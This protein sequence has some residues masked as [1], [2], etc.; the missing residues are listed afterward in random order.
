MGNVSAC[1]RGVGGKRVGGSAYGRVGV[2]EERV[3]GSAYGR[4]GVGEGNVSAGRRM[5]VSALAKGTCRRYWRLASGFW[6]LLVCCPRNTNFSFKEC[7][8]IEII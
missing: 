7:R 5:G 1:R 2:G 4:V 8:K 6:L 3:G